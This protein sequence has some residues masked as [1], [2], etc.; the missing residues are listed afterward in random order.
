MV[1]SARLED[2]SGR[3][4]RE[5]LLTAAASDDAQAV[6]GILALV[7]NDERRRELAAQTLRTAAKRGSEAV[8]VQLLAGH[9][10]GFSKEDLESALFSCAEGGQRAIFDVL[11]K[12]ESVDPL[13]AL[14]ADRA[15]PLIVAAFHGHVEIV[16]VCC[17]RFYMLTRIHNTK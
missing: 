4:N 10:E 6:A 2:S 15:S 8:C 7:Y 16:Q 1:Q 3:R 11:V 12:E 17:A 5:A 9:A 13:E 14:D